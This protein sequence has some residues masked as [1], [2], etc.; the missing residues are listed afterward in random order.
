MIPKEFKYNE[1]ANYQ[2][3]SAFK[4]K[5]IGIINQN[6]AVTSDNDSFHVSFP[7]IFEKYPLPYVESDALVQRCRSNWMLFWQNQLNFAIWVATSGSG[8]NFNTTYKIKV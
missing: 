3:S 6:I 2:D 4:I 7:N 5:T 8:V 1:N